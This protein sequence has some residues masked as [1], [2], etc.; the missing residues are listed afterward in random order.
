MHTG[1]TRNAGGLPNLYAHVRNIACDCHAPSSIRAVWLRQ[2][3]LMR[4]VGSLHKPPL[5]ATRNIIP[6]FDSRARARARAHSACAIRQ[7]RNSTPCMRECIARC[8][9][10][11]CRASPA[12][13][14]S[15]A[16][17][18][19]PGS[20]A[21]REMQRPTRPR[22]LP[23]RRRGKTFWEIIAEAERNEPKRAFPLLNLYSPV[24]RL[25]LYVG[26]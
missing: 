17:G 6:R 3:T 10:H 15:L 9:R 24:R 8:A 20:G 23:P 14:V 13:I 19:R 22:P 18:I 26:R 2:F 21:M 12:T 7:W 5:S 16:P 4:R 1:Y 11:V 25:Y